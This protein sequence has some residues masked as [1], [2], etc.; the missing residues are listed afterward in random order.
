VELMPPRG[1]EPTAATV[2]V[3]YRSDRL[4]L[5]GAGGETAVRARLKPLAP[6]TTLTPNDLGY[7]LRVVAL[8]SQAFVTGP[9][10]AVELDTCT[11]T[12]SAAPADL[13]CLVE[14]CASS[15]TPIT[16]CTCAITAR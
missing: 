2:R 13:S 5:P 16:G 10:F 15:G 4:H 1:Q 6:D 8:S 9:L 11:G 7:G 3:G 14:G 12:Q